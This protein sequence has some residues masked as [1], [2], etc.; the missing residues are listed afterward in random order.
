MTLSKYVRIG[1]NYY[2]KTKYDI[3]IIIKEHQEYENNKEFEGINRS[4]DEIEKEILDKSIWG[5]YEWYKNEINRLHEDN[6]NLKRGFYGKNDEIINKR[7]LLNNIKIQ[8]CK[9]WIQ[10]NY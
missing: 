4:Y 6:L 1:S 8:R 7:I 5:S 2:D 10:M 3:K 9:E